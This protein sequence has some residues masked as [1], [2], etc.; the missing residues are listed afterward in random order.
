M[1]TQNGRRLPSQSP[2]ELEP[3]RAKLP[4]QFLTLGD[5]RPGI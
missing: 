3:A 2:A 4:R 5:F 1:H